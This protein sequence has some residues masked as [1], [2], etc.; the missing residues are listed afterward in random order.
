VEDI[1]VEGLA[2]ICLRRFKEEFPAI[3]AYTFPDDD[4]AMVA[5]RSWISDVLYIFDYEFEQT[6]IW[7]I[8]NAPE[9][10]TFFFFI[11]DFLR[12]ILDSKLHA[13]LS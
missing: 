1:R 5:I 4:N 2:K 9:Y 6:V 8:R 10:S 13:V 12:E 3:S 11:R 7:K